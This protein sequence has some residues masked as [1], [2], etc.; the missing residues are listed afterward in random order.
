MAFG[1]RKGTDPSHQRISSQPGVERTEPSP[2]IREPKKKNTHPQ[3]DDERSRNEP[4]TCWGRPTAVRR[5]CDRGSAYTQN[6]SR[7]NGWS[8]RNMPS[9]VYWGPYGLLKDD[10]QGGT[11]LWCPRGLK[12]D[13]ERNRDGNE[14][15]G[16]AAADGRLAR[17]AKSG[18][19][20][21]RDK[22]GQ[23]TL[24]GRTCSSRC[25]GRT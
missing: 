21:R 19:L 25:G 10:L 5:I 2:P 17:D 15:P 4:H 18:A 20:L 6:V 16:G 13:R 3:N 1:G 12:I 7:A 23:Q 22:C 9:K 24:K 14:L 11:L 8:S